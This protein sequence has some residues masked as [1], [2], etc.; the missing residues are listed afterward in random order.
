MFTNIFSCLSRHRLHYVS[1]CNDIEL[2]IQFLLDGSTSINE[3]NF[4]KVKDWVKSLSSIF[5]IGPYSNRVGGWTLLSYFQ[6]LITKNIQPRSTAKLFCILLATWFYFYFL[7]CFNQ[8]IFASNA[9]RTNR[10][11]LIR[12]RCDWILVCYLEGVN[13][14]SDN[15]KTEFTLNQY[16]SNEEVEAA[17]DGINYIKG[18]TYTGKAINFTRVNSL[19]EAAGARP[20]V[21][22]V[23][24]ASSS[25]WRFWFCRSQWLSSRNL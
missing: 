17:I 7:F 23:N 15:P 5:E 13:Q 14:Y 8:N 18:R 3:E 4:A 2:D 25:W 22:K 9:V 1:V 16:S 12:S 11:L 10:N 24:I 20:Y 19:T 21:K 6:S